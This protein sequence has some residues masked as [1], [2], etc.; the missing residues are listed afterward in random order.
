MGALFCERFLDHTVK[1]TE[2]KNLLGGVMLF[3][4]GIGMIAGMMLGTL[5]AG[6]MTGSYA[7]AHSRFSEADSW[8]SH[9]EGL[10]LAFLKLTGLNADTSEA[11]MSL[12]GIHTIVLIFYTAMIAVIPVAALVSYRKIPDTGFR[13]LIWA[14]FV[15]AA[16]ILVGYICGML[17]TANWRLSPL[18]VTG[19]LVSM[20][21]LRLL[22][23]KRESRRVSLLL[24]LPVGYYCLQSAMG[25]VSLPVNN[26][27][28]NDS[29]LLAQYLQEEGLSYGYATFWNSQA[30]TLQSDS[31]CKVRTVRIDETGVSEN[32]YQSNI[33]WFEDQPEQEEYFLLM[34]A[35]EERLMM[36]SDSPLL[37]KISR[38]LNY[39]GYAIWIFEE[40]LF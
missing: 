14:H 8:W 15:S 26:H 35:S 33:H 13:L 32:T 3:L 31:A 25:V 39:E 36:R 1:L 22:W 27:L 40:N 5:L 38:E 7:N 18:I 2:K 17:Y 16:L 19:F 9:L 6:G 34:S 10:P 23:Q 29:Y 11:L 37:E 28:E 24:L 20:S 30:I 21:F 4:C 12:S